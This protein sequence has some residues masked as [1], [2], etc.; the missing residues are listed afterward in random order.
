MIQPLRLHLNLRFPPGAQRH[1]ALPPLLVV[2][3]LPVVEQQ[4]GRLLHVPIQSLLG[5]PKYL[6]RTSP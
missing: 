3:F 1:I 2:Y 6:Q 4:W 5:K